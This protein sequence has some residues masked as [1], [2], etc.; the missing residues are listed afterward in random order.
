M[1]YFSKQLKEWTNSFGK[2][3]IHRNNFSLNDLNESYKEKYGL[4]RTEI[5]KMF[6]NGINR[7]IK[8]LEVGSNVGNQ[9]I[10]LQDM[11]FNNLYGIE[12]QPYA[13]EILKK[14]TENI[15]IIKG[16]AFDIPFKDGYFDVVFTSGVLIHIS[17]LDIK[18]ALKEIYR[19]SKRYIWG[20]EYYS[21]KYEGIR[22]R[23]KTNLLWK[24]NFS[25]IYLDSF[26]GLKLVKE[27]KIK[28]LQDDNIDTMF[29]IEKEKDK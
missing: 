7:D 4:T 18:K 12:P 29:F 25:Q 8:I 16:S 1:K 28:Y 5:N 22:Y 15:N 14:K 13:V 10:C 6:L 3:Y 19:C 2:Q 21:N 24:A 20:F 11:G 27:K 23:G 17:P 26:K 9:L